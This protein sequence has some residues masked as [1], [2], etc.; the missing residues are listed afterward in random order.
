LP[1]RHLGLVTAAE[2]GLSRAL[3]DEL[4]AAI[5]ASVDIDRLLQLARSAVVPSDAEPA[6]PFGGHRAM[7]RAR[8]GVARDVAFQFYYPANL[9]LLRAAGAE[10][11][12]WSPLHDTEL[13]D[14]DAL[15]LGGGY[16]EVHAGRLAANVPMREAVKAFALA[17]HPVY[18]ECGG[19]LYLTDALEDEAGTLQP[20]VGVLPT[21]GRMAPKRLTLG[22]AEVEATRETLLGPAGTVARG[23]EFHASRIDEVPERVAR[24]YTV[25]MSRGG[26]PRAEGYLIGETLMSY[27]HL[28][29]GS[30]PAVPDHLVRHA[31]N[32]RRGR[33]GAR[34]TVT[35]SP[36]GS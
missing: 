35:S 18:A 4:V 22:Y 14:V 10:L 23:H 7:A 2:Q 17:G 34:V 29:F 6:R 19:L 13:P 16:P 28:H 3:L 12:F 15:Y 31:D 9:D 36:E 26:A 8:I 30:N 20:M 33:L 25:R 21:V 32:H 1:E 27:V 5:E 24:A 11:V